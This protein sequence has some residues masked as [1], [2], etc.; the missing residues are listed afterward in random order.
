MQS[1]KVANRIVLGSVA[2]GVSFG[3]GLIANRDFKKAWLTGLIT[4]PASYVGTVVAEQRRTNQEKLIRAALQNQVQVLEGQQTLVHQSLYAATAT[5]QE[6]EASINAL[7]GERSNLL[8]RVSELHNQRNA[9]YQEIT[10]F[11]SQKQQQEGQLYSLQT[12]VQ[13]F[14]RQQVELNQS[15]TAKTAQI[16]QTETRLKLLREELEQLQIPST[17]KRKQQEQLNQEIAKLEGR[18]QDLE[19]EVHDLR[20]QIQVFEQRQEQLNQTLGRLQHQQQEVEANLTSGQAELEQLLSQVSEKQ[21]QQEQLNQ[22][23]ATLE[24]RKQ[25]LEADSRNLE[26]QIQELEKQKTTRPQTRPQEFEGEISNFLPEEWRE[27]LEFTK[28]LSEDER[29]ALKAILEQD[30]AALKRIAAEKSTMPQVLIDSINNNALQTFGDTLF[31]IAGGLGVPEVHEEYSPIFIEPIAVYFKD[32]LELKDKPSPKTPLVREEAEPH[33][34]AFEVIIPPITEGW[35]CIHTLEYSANSVTISPD[36]QMLISGG[37]DGNIKLWNLVTG[38]LLDT[39]SGHSSSV[40]SVATSPDGQL[41][42]SG[43]GDSTIKLWKLNTRELLHTFTGHTSSVSSVATSPDG[44]IIASGSYD[45][46]IKLWDVTTRKPIRTLQ[47][48]SSLVSS[49]TFS[50]RTHQKILAAGVQDGQVLQ[51]DLNTDLPPTTLLWNHS[52]VESVTIS[53]DCNTL[54]I[55]DS[56]GLIKI[57]NLYM[58]VVFSSFPGNQGSVLAVAVS[59]DGKKLLT[60]GDEVRLWDLDSRKLIETFSEHS[61]KVCAVAF[62][63]KG[64]NFVSS[65]QDGTIKVWQYEVPLKEK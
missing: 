50:S 34:A 4:L 52:R 21:K 63:A 49:I 58:G 17:D 10:D 56:E 51:W 16:Q 45:K 35:H 1:T 54:I 2:F 29:T 46:S 47:G 8:S 40:E 59:R 7:Q 9:L 64:E 44:K 12:Q 36:S 23:L 62:S 48:V 31:V 28:H 24:T 32:L 19:G 22:D 39:L 20:T 26:T 57:L 5:R 65:S 38:E 43:S 14:E 53:P 41:L 11:Q 25:Q 15:L 42:Y 61:S 13:Q 6:V 3:L 55:G 30:E 60:A 37:K 27:W 33:V 18:K